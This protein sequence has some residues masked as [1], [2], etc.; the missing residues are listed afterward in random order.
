MKFFN[1][2]AITST[3]IFAL[4]VSGL[5]IEIKTEA[6]ILAAMQKKEEEAKAEEEANPTRNDYPSSRASKQPKYFG[7]P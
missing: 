5:V 2:L 3:L 1:K 4:G 7:H 6:D